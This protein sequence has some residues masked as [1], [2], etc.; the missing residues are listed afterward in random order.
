MKRLFEDRVPNMRDI[1]GYATPHGAIPE[2]RFIRSNWLPEL[3]DE[4][5]QYL[6]R[7]GIK[8]AVDLRTLEECVEDIA[9]FEKHVDFKVFHY[10]FVHGA[11]IPASTD[12]IPQTYLQ[13]ADE[14]ETIKEI[15]TTIFNADGGAVYY[16]FAGKDRTGVVTALIMLTLGASEDDIVDDYTLSGVYLAEKLQEYSVVYNI[17]IDIFTPRPRYMREFLAG[18]KQKYGNIDSYLQQIGLSGE[19]MRRQVFGRK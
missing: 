19:Q 9:V 13:I 4:D 3:A 16:C 14:T 7:L 10:P 5:L 6:R 2:G 8:T 12:E 1:G 17:D 18:F 11:E 15:L